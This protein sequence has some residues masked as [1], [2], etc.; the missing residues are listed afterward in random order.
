MNGDVIKEFLVS[1]G[2]QI[3][4]EGQFADAIGKATILAVGLGTAAVAAAGGIFKMVT[5]IADDVDALGDLSNRI[6]VSI[7]DIEEIGYVAQ[8]SG[9]SFE[10]AQSSLESFSK[11]AGDAAN[12]MGRG[13]KVFDQLGVSVTNS[14]GKL[15]NAVVLMQEVGDKIKDMERG[16]QVA[17]LERLGIDKTMLDA[18]TTDVSELRN[19]FKAL[20]SATGYDANAAAE[21]AGALNDSLDKLRYTLT[22]VG[23]AL[24]VQFMDRFT[25]SVDSLRKLIMDNLPK[26]MR[27]ITPV[28]K[29][30]LGIADAFIAIVYRIAQGAGVIIGWVADII[31]SLNG[32]VVAIGAVVVAWKYLNLAFLATPVGMILALAA[33]IGLLIDDFMTWQE[34]GESLIPWGKWQ[35]EIELVIDILGALKDIA[36][37]TFQFVFAMIDALISLF[38]GDLEGAVRKVGMMFETLEDIIRSVF[39]DTAADVFHGF[40]S[41]MGT[42]LS[43]VLS[44]FSK[45]ATAVGGAISFIRGIIERNIVT[46][47]TVFEAIAP[48]VQA[49]FDII[50]AIVV[51][52]FEAFAP[53]VNAVFNGIK[54]TIRGLSS[55][56]QSVFGGIATIVDGV[57]SKITTMIG[58]I[59]KAADAAKS[60]GSLFEDNSVNQN[61]ALGA[62]PMMAGRFGSNVTINQDTTVQVQ[63]SAD[64]AATGRNVAGQQQAVNG[65]M[66]RNLKGA[67]R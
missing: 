36:G 24:A 38:T 23:R 11:T 26:I 4:G 56:V 62:S 25:E 52:T 46:I 21:K 28:I 3:E 2:F 34:G 7:E 49:V 15:K 61:P 65:D 19:E 13:K 14:S 51:G 6:G 63:G 5:A 66:V 60:V 57:V 40:I 64:P 1:L 35:N 22:V 43:T 33:A 8:L 32:W 30:I 53:V 55:V 54:E 42:V 31:D 29:I 37:Q 67:V 17:I 27:V 41:I 20:Y 48:V 59:G 12:G 10:S 9:S 18:L 45:V 58:W 47:I 16:K 44:V 39:G 50:R